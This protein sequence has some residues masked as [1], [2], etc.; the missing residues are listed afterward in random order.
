MP[1]NP[2]II[3]LA[4]KLL[5]DNG[6]ELTLDIRSVM[7]IK[8]LDTRTIEMQVYNTQDLLNQTF[9]EIAQQFLTTIHLI[10]EDDLIDEKIAQAKNTITNPSQ[11]SERELETAKEILKAHALIQN[12]RTLDRLKSGDETI[13][14]ESV[15]LLKEEIINITMQDV[16]KFG[17]VARYLPKYA[18]GYKDVALAAVNSCPASVKFLPEDLEGYKDIALAAVA[19]NAWAFQFIK[20]PFCADRDIALQAVKKDGWIL[21]SMPQFC[22]DEEIVLHA[23]QNED[24]HGAVLQFASPNLHNNKEIAY[25]ALRKDAYTAFRYLSVNLQNNADIIDFILDPANEGG[26]FLREELLQ[27]A[28]EFGITGD[29]R[30]IAEGLAATNRLE[31]PQCSIMIHRSIDC[32][33]SFIGDNID[34]LSVLFNALNDLDSSARTELTEIEDTLNNSADIELGGDSQFNI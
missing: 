16:D 26:K 19:K 17:L 28:E 14:P 22:N 6:I 30:T 21:Q 12:C 23:V 15:E 29:N 5:N 11:T 33:D 1:T 18:P 24:A 3:P 2:L 9:E 32:E 20:T 10:R 25:A 27:Q 4:A 34:F 31:A 13:E 7:L 8:Y